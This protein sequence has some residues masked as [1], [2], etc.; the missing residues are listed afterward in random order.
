MLAGCPCA[1]GCPSC[2]QSP[3]CGNL[4]DYA[5]QGRRG[6]CSTR[7]T[8]RP[9]DGGACRFRA[10]RSS[11]VV[12][13]TIERE[14][15]MQ[16]PGTDLRRRG[17]L[18]GARDRGARARD[19]RVHG[20]LAGATVTTGGNELDA[21]ATATTVRVR[22]RRDARHRRPVRRGE[23][24]PRRLLRLRVRLDRRG[25]DWA[26]QDPG[27]EHGAVEVRPVHVEEESS[28]EVRAL[29]DEQ[30]DES[31]LGADDAGGG[32]G[33]RAPRRC[34]SGT[35]SSTSSAPTGVLG[36]GTSSTAPSTAKTVRVARRRDGRHRRPVRR[37]EGADR[38]L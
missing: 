17:P 12:E 3:K 9:E 27:G 33:G 21:I 22:G 26:A 38:R 23:G 20:A 37:D 35:R 19:G 10:P 34:R 31:P 32:G 11:I 16:Y 36:R 28:R 13:S 15:R 18:A 30:R 14:E 25:L 8:C 6:R 1:D 7:M 24:G 2:V 4:N 5:R 29:L